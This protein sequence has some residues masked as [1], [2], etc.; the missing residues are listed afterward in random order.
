MPSKTI[1]ITEQVYAELKKLK[2][3]NESF[4]EL[5]LR[6]ARNANGQKLQEFFGTWEIDDEEWAGISDE[7]GK[8]RQSGKVSEVRL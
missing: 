2:Q 7:L 1:T 8:I 4:S 6:L 5:L 3:E